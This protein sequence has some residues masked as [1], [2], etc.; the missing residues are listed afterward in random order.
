MNVKGFN[1]DL[2][3]LWLKLK[4]GKNRELHFHVSGVGELGY[5]EDDEWRAISAVVLEGAEE[6]YNLM[7]DESLTAD[8]LDILEYVLDLAIEG[9]LER[10]WRLHSIEPVL[11]ISIKLRYSKQFKLLEMATVHNK[12]QTFNVNETSDYS[13]GMEPSLVI[14]DGYSRYGMYISIHGG[15][16]EMISR[17][18]KLIKGEISLEDRRIRSMFRNGILYRDDGR[19]R[20]KQQEQE[21]EGYY[22]E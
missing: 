5:R 16:M 1:K 14:R 6:E 8:E 9:K 20:K 18:L 7:G 22:N 15:N 11:D 21:W 13:M 12:S 17:Y 3:S 10:S 4:I 2:K 19:F